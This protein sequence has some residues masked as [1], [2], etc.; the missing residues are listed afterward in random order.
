MP[1][2]QPSMHAVSVKRNIM[3]ETGKEL[4]ADTPP[5]LP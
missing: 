1:S 2:M 3:G 5:S 4:K